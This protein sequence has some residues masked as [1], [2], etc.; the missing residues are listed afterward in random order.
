MVTKGNHCGPI[1]KCDMQK[2]S[3]PTLQAPARVRTRTDAGPGLS[4]WLSEPFKIHSE[5]EKENFKISLMWVGLGVLSNV[6]PDQLWAVKQVLIMDF[7]VSCGFV[8]P[9]RVIP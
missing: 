6:K 5:K 8:S 9:I 1:L 7:R 4:C 3:C 2:T